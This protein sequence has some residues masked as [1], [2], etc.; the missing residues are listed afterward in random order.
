MAQRLIDNRH[1]TD[2]ANAIR[3]LN[4]SQETYKPR[5]MADAI[6]NG[7]NNSYSMDDIYVINWRTTEIAPYSLAR[8]YDS[9][10]NTGSQGFFGARIREVRPYS[11]GNA[12][13]YQDKLTTIGTGAFNGQTTLTRIDLPSSVT[14]IQPYA[15]TGCPALNTLILRSELGPDE[16][17]MTNV[18]QIFETLIQIE[19]GK[20]WEA[21]QDIYPVY[22]QQVAT[23]VPRSVLDKWHTWIT[24]NFNEGYTRLVFAIEDYPELNVGYPDAI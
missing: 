17:G 10:W 20:A 16:Y 11:L 13:F 6:L 5:E 7:D 19:Q 24:E 14:T 3:I 18:A 23:Y 12:G 9:G 8:Y 4:N 21:P 2:I 22:G 15:F 1:L